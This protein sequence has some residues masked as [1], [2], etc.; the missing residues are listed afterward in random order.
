MT[1]AKL[2]PPDS[3]QRGGLA[4]QEGL[5][6]SLEQ[7]NNL[8]YSSDNLMMEVTVDNSEMFEVRERLSN[9]S[10]LLGVPLQPGTVEVTARLVGAGG[11]QL[12]SPL[13][14][15]AR[16]EILPKMVLEPRETF[17]PWDPL[18]ETQHLVQHRLLGGSG[19]GVTWGS[20]NT[21]VATTTQAGLTKVYGGELGESSV[22]TQ[23]SRHK[24]CQAAARVE[25]S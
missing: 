21:S 4:G 3:H 13:T 25:V 14:T 20:S 22:V 19:G 5:G 23:L 16:L 18:T 8:I 9:G 1:P 11:C 7:E 12:T 10:L 15:T 24:H 6:A 2:Q 17:L